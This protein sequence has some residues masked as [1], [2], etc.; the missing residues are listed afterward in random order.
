MG[1]HSEEKKKINKKMIIVIMILCVIILAVIV[2]FLVK[3]KNWFNSKSNTSIENVKTIENERLVLKNNSDYNKIIEFDFEDN[4]VK[5]IKI[6]EQ[7]E[8]NEKYE[9]KKNTYKI[10]QDI[11]L[12]EANDKKLAI[13][14][15]R[16]NLGS[17]E[18]LSYEQVYDKYINQ[19]IDI[20]TVI[21]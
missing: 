11:N 3:N 14:I 20:Y 13:E 9:E 8:E 1:K 17:D 15:E 7:F 2:G 6:Y 4:K 18:G 12:I 16:K 5:T 10:A 19:L 21:K